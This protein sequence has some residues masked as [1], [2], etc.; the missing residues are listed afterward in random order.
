METSIKE[1]EARQN[2][3][4]VRPSTFIYTLENKNSIPTYSVLKEKFDADF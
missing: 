2:E 3:I 4:V 1:F